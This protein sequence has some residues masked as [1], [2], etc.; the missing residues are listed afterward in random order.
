MKRACLLL[1]LLAALGLMFAACARNGDDPGPDIGAP[2]P[3]PT[4]AATNGGGAAPAETP[5]PGPTPIPDLGGMEILIGSWFHNW[6]TDTADPQTLG[7]EMRWEDR[8]YVQER[9]NFRIREV[10]LGEFGEIQEL[11]TLSITAGEPA[12]HIFVLTPV[13][14]NTLNAQGMFHDLDALPSTNWSYEETGIPWRADIA[15]ASRF[16]GSIR[17]WSTDTGT[18][19]GLFFNM[20]LFEEAGLDRYLPFDLQ[21]SGDWTWDAL[22]EIGAALTRDIDG[23]GIIDTWA[24]AFF[25]AYIVD[26]ALASNLAY[27]VG[28]DPYTGL[29]YNATNTPE[30]FEALEFIKSLEARGYHMP[31]PEGSPWYWWEPAFLNGTAAIHGRGEWLA[32]TVNARLDDPWGFV[33]FPAGPNNPYGP[34]FMGNANIHGIP[35]TFSAEEAD[36]IMFAYQQWIRPIPGWDDPDGWKVSA[37]MRH[38]TPRSVDETLAMFNRD[39]ARLRPAFHQ[40]VD[41]PVH[42]DFSWP[43]FYLGIDVATQI[44]QGQL[45]IEE[46]IARGNAAR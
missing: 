12:A 33:A 36:K 20:R 1:F 11:A 3:A 41:A 16:G 31:Q 9:Y 10:T 19:P 6:C 45:I 37:Y 15:E 39:P 43:I 26:Y 27:Y 34:R 21:L 22:L 2:T 13:W 7:D 42:Y 5:A 17:G 4:P 23:D 30:F 40:W 29:F 46:A 28:R 44:E 8:M 35:A 25:N 38:Y 32:G 18:G 14:F 24:F